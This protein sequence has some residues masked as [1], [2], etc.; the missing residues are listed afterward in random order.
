MWNGG[1]GAGYWALSLADGSSEV[2]VGIDTLNA[3]QPS[4]LG[5]LEDHNFLTTTHHLL[6]LLYVTAVP[7]K[8]RPRRPQCCG[9]YP[10]I[11]DL[12]EPE[13]LIRPLHFF[14][15]SHSDVILRARSH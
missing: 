10:Q 6:K 1:G 11:L 3:T 9:T 14:F 13:H 2:G 12:P 8:P 15:A 4:G 5:F 7:K